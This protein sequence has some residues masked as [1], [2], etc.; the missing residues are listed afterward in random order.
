VNRACTPTKLR[1]QIEELERKSRS[2]R[3]CTRSCTTRSSRGN[4]RAFCRPPESS[5]PSPSCY[6][7][8]RQQEH[9]RAS[10]RSRGSRQAKRPQKRATQLQQYRIILSQVFE[11]ISQLVRR[12]QTSPGVMISLLLSLLGTK[13]I[14]CYNR[15]TCIFTN[16]RK[17]EDLEKNRLSLSE[18]LASPLLHPH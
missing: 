10:G 5:C 16:G 3:T 1:K 11:E 13:R 14:G 18:T 7:E 6:Q 15:C 12:R 2:K 4:I 8:L 9:R 17:R